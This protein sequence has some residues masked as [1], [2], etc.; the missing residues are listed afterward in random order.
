MIRTKSLV[1]SIEDVPR[2]WVF[3]YYLNL[4]ETLSGQS[5]KIKS[6]FNIQDSVPSMIIY[7][8]HFANCYKF[9]DFSSGYSGSHIDL[10]MLLFNLTYPQACAKIID[11]YEKRINDTDKIPVYDSV[12]HDRYK[13]SDYEIKKWS[14]LDAEYWTSFGISS[15]ILSKYNVFPLS[16]YMMSK[17]NLDGSI[18]SIKMDKLY[19]YGYFKEDGT[20]YKIYQPKIPDKKFIKVLNYTQGYEQLTKTK[21]YLLIL[22]SL[23]DIMSFES[24]GIGNVECVAPDAEGVLIQ[25]EIITELKNKYE[26]SLTL[27]DNDNPGRKASLKYKDTYDINFI[28]FDLSK[29]ISDSIKDYGRTF[30]LKSL[31]PILQENFK[32]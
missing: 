27:F 9:K 11:T 2:E 7:Q 14:T 30:V 12:I 31:F 16:Y 29:D 26:G 10:V 19:L 20:L 28:S 15:Q 32:K 13:V 1:S 17:T 25:Q 8:D 18:S 3:E 5:V 6:V 24:L 23:K 22:S 4:K 21:K